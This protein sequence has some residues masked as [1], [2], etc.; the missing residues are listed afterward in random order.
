[1]CTWCSEPRSTA[2]KTGGPAIGAALESQL[3]VSTS[4]AQRTVDQLDALGE[5]GVDPGSPA[6]AAIARDLGVSPARLAAA[7][8]AG[9]QSG[10][11]K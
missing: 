11:G 5:G 1:L 7:L 4:A 9:K 2:G 3:G 8:K 10:A 6:F